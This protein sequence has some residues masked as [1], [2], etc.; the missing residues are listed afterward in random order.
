MATYR[1][2]KFGYII[3]RRTY[4][5]RILITVMRPISGTLCKGYVA[6]EVY[7]INLIILTHK[8]RFFNVT[9]PQ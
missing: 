2:S 1:T 3:P 4:I 9:V 6:V 8:G 7:Y 5:L